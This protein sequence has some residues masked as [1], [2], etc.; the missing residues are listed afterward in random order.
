MQESKSVCPICGEVMSKI[1]RMDYRKNDIR[2][3]LYMCKECLLWSSVDADLEKLVLD[4][5]PEAPLFTG[6]SQV[7][8]HDPFKD[9][10]AKW[11]FSRQSLDKCLSMFGGVSD[12]G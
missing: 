9:G 7:L 11:F 4:L 5:H 12:A 6:Y 3:L 8:K 10:S 1:V 2:T